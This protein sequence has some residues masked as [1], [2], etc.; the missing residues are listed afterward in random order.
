MNSLNEPNVEHWFLFYFFLPQFNS[1]KARTKSQIHTWGYLFFILFE[2]NIWASEDLTSVLKVQA[3][4][5][6]YIKDAS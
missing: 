3:T 1:G 4:V 5:E 6:S 2:L